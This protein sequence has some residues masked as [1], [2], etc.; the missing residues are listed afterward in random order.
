MHQRVGMYR[1]FIIFGSSVKLIYIVQSDLKSAIPIDFGAI[2]SKKGANPFS[3]RQNIPDKRK[4]T[5]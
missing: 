5:K 1:K 3:K 2:H 4:Q